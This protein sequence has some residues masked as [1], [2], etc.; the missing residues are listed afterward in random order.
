MK[1]LGNEISSALDT[2][3]E[4]LNYDFFKSPVE[5]NDEE[6][7]STVF[8]DSE[9]MKKIMESKVSSFNSAKKI[10]DKW[11]NSPNAPHAKTIRAYIQKVVSAGDMAIDILRTALCQDIDFKSLEPHKHDAAIKAKP[12]IL[13]SIFDLESSLKELKEKLESDD[14]SLSDKEFRIGYPERFSKGEFFPIKDYW[15]DWYD[16]KKDAVKICPFSSSGD[17]I[18][19]ENLKII[20]PKLPRDKSKI[21]FYNLPKNEQYWRRQELPKNIIFENSDLWD[22]FIKEEFRRRREG[23]WFMNN[24]KPVYL[25]GNHYFALQWC[26]M[27][28]SGGYMDFRYA[29][30][31]MFYHLEACFIDDRCLGQIFVKSRRTGFTY[32]ILSIILNHSTSTKNKNFG[33]TSKSDSDARKAF[34]KYR[35]MLLNLPF[36]FLPTIKGKLDSPKEFEFSAPLNSSKEVKKN[37]N[38]NSNDYL[39]NYI[40]YEPTKNDS[41]DGQSLYIYFG[42]ECG[43]WRSPN[44]YVQHFGQISPTMLEGGVVVGKAFIGS[45]VGAMNKGGKQFKDMYDLSDITKRNKITSM[46]TTGL[47]RYFLQAQDNMTAFT[48]KY[49]V[50]HKV[51]PKRKTWNVNGKLIRIGSLDYLISQEESKKKESDK[52]LNEQYRAFPRKIEHAFRD[53]SSEC[54][55]NITKLYEQLEHNENL[56]EE[57][58][59]TV[60]NFD[61]ENGIDS[62][63]VFFPNSKGRFKI[64][65]IPSV[66]DDTEHLMNRVKKV[67][68]MYYPLNGDVL[69]FGCDP[70]SLKS[71]HGEGSK[72]GL[73]GKT[74][75]FPE[76]GAPSNSFIVEY[77]SRPSDEIIFF[78]DVIKCIY[79]YGAPILVESNR[80]DL[81]RH[82]RNRGYRGF[83]MDRLDRPKNKLNANEKEYGGQTMSNKDILDSHLNAIGSWIERYV[84][85]S[86]NE[87]FRKIGEIGKMPFDETLRD[88]LNFDPDNRN[89]HDAT[90]S[91]GLAIMA[92][93]TEKYKGKKKNKKEN[94]NVMNIFKKYN[95]KGTISSVI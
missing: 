84:G 35:Y 59:F 38:I 30:L 74:L 76:G 25:T 29:Q 28:D 17:T 27:L 63:V 12:V 95:N 11:M 71:T 26:K 4:G 33:I 80:I 75:M 93:Q 91:S 58:R 49:G 46:T 42:D 6:N 5:I 68:D 54:V 67:G 2:I 44:D 13:E 85:I 41:Y 34:I 31:Y 24:G 47:Y 32:I 77:I 73:H 19:L 9:K 53:K 62:N 64:S 78:E 43:K 87:Q 52:A 39:N 83:V 15:K 37:K 45:T 48:D 81:L 92:C 40:D 70:F 23:V 55:F 72:G 57:T 50:C 66:V 1:G 16:K 3:I 90:I 18:V 61:W 8:L 60:G 22:D 94:V 88:W 69:R 21:L 86:T 10:L 82:M 14:L 20:L 51:A 7:F 89:K 36:F 56:P 65:W 79:F